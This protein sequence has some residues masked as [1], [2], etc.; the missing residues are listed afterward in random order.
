MPVVTKKDSNDLN[1][2]MTFPDTVVDRQRQ[3]G[4]PHVCGY[5]DRETHPHLQWTHIQ[6]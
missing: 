2:G 3:T 1:S 6:N 5:R 4:V